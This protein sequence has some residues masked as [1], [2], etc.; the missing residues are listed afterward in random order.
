MRLPSVKTLKTCWTPDTARAVRKALEKA[1]PGLPRTIDDALD[2]VN[3]LIG[4]YGVEAIRDDEW[5]T[6]YLDIG[7]LY[8]NAGDPYITTI[9]YDTRKQNF[10]C[11]SWGDVV[12]KQEKRFRDH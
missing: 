7:L 4:G 11:T 3:T 1:D 6:Y 9:V 2:T 12:E 10:Y 8:V 5:T